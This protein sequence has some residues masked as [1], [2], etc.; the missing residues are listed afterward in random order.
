MGALGMLNPPSNF[1]ELL[2]RYRRLQVIAPHPDDE[3]FG[4]AGLVQLA[5]LKGLKITVHIATDGENC[6]GS[7]PAGKELELRKARR[8]ESCY[9]SQLLGYPEPQFWD[10]GDGQLSRQSRRLQALI[11]QH[12]CR[13]TLWVAPWQEDGHP[14]H[15]ATGQA[16]SALE[17]PSLFYPVWALVDSVRLTSF[18]SKDRICSLDLSANLLER[19]ARAAQL[20]TTQFA[21][22]QRDEGPVIAHQHLQHF[23]TDKEMYWHAN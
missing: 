21:D 15:N 10:L 4:A 7:L 9:A 14:D 19:K 12:H 2:A 6:F 17:L 16:V 3:V 20:F 8:Q 5:A 22:D 18:L 13:E 1:K 11:Q 23:V